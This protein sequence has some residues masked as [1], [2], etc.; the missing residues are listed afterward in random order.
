MTFDVV[1]TDEAS[2]QVLQIQDW[3]AE[4]SITGAELWL[5]ALRLAVEKLRLRGSAFSS[6]PESP[7]FPEPLYQIL[8]RTRRGLTY[9]ALF[10]VRNQTV[11][12]VSVR[13][14]GRDLVGPDDVLL[15]D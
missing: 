6:A 3:I 2:F 1:F 11:Y 13:G 12:V 9:R 10:I 4:R 14:F 7:Q 5:T 8:F 15:P